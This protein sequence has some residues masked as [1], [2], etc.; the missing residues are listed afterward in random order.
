MKLNSLKTKFLAGF[1]PLFV[2]SF[3]VFFAISYYM[4]S[5]ALFRYADELSMQIGQTAAA[6]IEREFQKSETYIEDLSYDDAITSGDH[7][8]QLAALQELQKRTNNAFAMVA[9][10]DL[11]GQ[12]FNE[13][14]KAMDRASREYF[15]AVKATGKPFMTGPSVSGSNG[16]LITIICYP[17][18]N[19]SGELIGMV[20]GTKELDSIS[21][22]VGQIKYFDTGR[23]FI[24]DQS[25]ITIAY[26]QLPETVGKMDL[27]K[28]QQEDKV[29]D[30]ALVDGFNRAL[31]ED[32][33]VQ[34]NY[35]ASRGD[36]SV[37]VMTPVHLAN[38][39]WVAVSVA[40]KAE[41][42][43]DANRLIKVMGIVGLIM[44]LAI[45]TLIWVISGI[46]C[47]PVEQLRDECKLLA[48]GDLRQRDTV[49]DRN[50]EIGDLSRGF[51][52]MRATI[53]G[54]IA[55]ISDHSQKLSASAEELTAASHQT[56]DAASQTAQIMVDM[57]DGINKQSEAATSADETTQTIA[58][59]TQTAS[60]NANALVTVT[61]MTV[62]SV[63]QGR[64]SIQQVVAAMD[65][66]SAATDT[67]QRV[68]DKL[69]KSSEKIGEIVG[70]ISGI[71]E[72]TNLLALNAAI[73]AAR[74]G[75][76]GRGFAV[77]A[78]EVRKLA[79]ESANSTQQIA[80]LV[81]TIQNDMKEA[82]TASD[83]SVNS[84]NASRESVQQ[85]DGVFESIRVAIEALAG[86][87]N[88]FST[89]MS[90][91]AAGA[92]DMQQA[93]DSIKEISDHN[94]A[95]AQ[96]VSATTEEQSASSEEIAAATRTLAE[97]A[98]DLAA[99]VQK[100]KV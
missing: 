42:C 81:T 13:K 44:I 56:A 67:V 90:E 21:D 78:D 36:D 68:V 10:M 79:E 71:A 18:K 92:Q 74:A 94:A 55:N 65:K 89:V 84:V 35:K 83:A 8:K 85:A 99:E 2:G 33:Q 38:R 40:P 15:K 17:V 16:K 76:A 31:Q 53:R 88:E 73:E 77:V 70:M 86:G 41:V 59:Q 75:E 30:Q 66:I 57:T 72:Q 91:V 51:A 43:A 7:A 48:D 96:S 23:V 69:D 26:A 58:S 98:T 52:S 9:Y 3:A 80:E 93:A 87:I 37:A 19:A 62:D 32:K 28:T 4:S 60:D 39:T 97:Q 22:I 61:N 49:I 11:N 14:D 46:M 1:L 100:F 45:A 47:K 25:G 12:A 6:N 63:Q 54:L 64:D 24:A 5:S 50:D 27:T 20:Y 29:I 82:V 95:Q 34:S